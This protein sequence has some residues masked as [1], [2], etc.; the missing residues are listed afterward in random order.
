MSKYGFNENE[1]KKT[2]VTMIDKDGFHKETVYDGKYEASSVPVDPSAF[3]AQGW[4]AEGRSVDPTMHHII[5]INV[6]DTDGVFYFSNETDTDYEFNIGDVV[7]N[8]TEFENG[9]NNSPVLSDIKV[10]YG[11][12]EYESGTCPEIVYYQLYSLNRDTHTISARTKIQ[13][14]YE[15]K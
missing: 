2:I 12:K 15:G 11:T 8:N 13:I 3:T 14:V 10:R 4:C 7:L 6:P 1:V 9:L 5:A